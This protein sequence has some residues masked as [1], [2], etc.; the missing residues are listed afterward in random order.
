[1]QLHPGVIQWQGQEELELVQVKYWDEEVK[2]IP[3]A[4]VQLDPEN[5]FPFPA[6]G[7]EKLVVLPTSM[8]V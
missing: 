5:K 7:E 2:C 3:K 8:I 1:M 6:M 4:A